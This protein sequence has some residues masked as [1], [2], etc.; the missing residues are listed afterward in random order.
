MFERC[1]YFN[2]NHLART[3]EK[4]WKQAYAELGLAP[5][6]AYMLRLVLERPGLAQRDIASE[7]NLEKSTITRFIDKM[8][9][10]GYV[11]RAS[12]NNK[13]LAIFPTNKAKKIHKFHILL[14][15]N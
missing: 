13:E 5:S 14:V 11:Q 1:L 7:L 8:E 2:S 9:T 4:I 15:M 12:A 3:V 6:H 10:E